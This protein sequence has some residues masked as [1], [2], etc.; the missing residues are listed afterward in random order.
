MNKVLR[1]C[2]HSLM[3]A[4]VSC[5]FYHLALESVRKSV[6]VLVPL[7]KELYFEGE[8]LVEANLTKIK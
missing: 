8:H 7:E 2:N 1:K 5:V 6:G 4:L 3:R